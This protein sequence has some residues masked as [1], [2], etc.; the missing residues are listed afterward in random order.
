MGPVV[1][2]HPI[3]SAGSSIAGFRLAERF[4]DFPVGADRGNAPSP[5]TGPGR[6]VTDES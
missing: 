1:G 5:V 4:A 3:V 2:L 6:P